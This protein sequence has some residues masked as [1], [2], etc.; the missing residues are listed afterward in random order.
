MSASACWVLATSGTVYH[1]V[2]TG[3][4]RLI[5]EHGANLRSARAGLKRSVGLMTSLVF[6]IMN[7]THNTVR[8]SELLVQVRRN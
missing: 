3:N 6:G 7:S 8:T 5:R 1:L 4:Q 2:Q